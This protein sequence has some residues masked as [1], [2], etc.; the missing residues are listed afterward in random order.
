MRVAAFHRCNPQTGFTLLEVLVALGI[1]ATSLMAMY[2]LSGQMLQSTAAVDQRA[3]ALWCAD[4]QLITV[5]LARFAPPAGRLEAECTQLG[6]RY[7]VEQVVSPTPN[8]LLRRIEI[9]VFDRTATNADKGGRLAFL[10]TVLPND[11]GAR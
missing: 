1:A 5:S 9:S 10:A 11:A 3:A 4:N 2:S 8:P 6:R 7:T